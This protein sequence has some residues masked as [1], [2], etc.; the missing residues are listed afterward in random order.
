MAT[1]IGPQSALLSKQV[2]MMCH[3]VQSTHLP[4]ALDSANAP[5]VVVAGRL[6]RVR[7]RAH[8]SWGCCRVVPDGLQQRR[9]LQLW[10]CLHIGAWRMRKQ[11]NA[12]VVKTWR[13]SV[14][15]S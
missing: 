8:G 14:A 7:G 2:M 5:Q 15:S 11:R 13:L 3:E 4:Q 12:A 9:V 10:Q 6:P 1:C